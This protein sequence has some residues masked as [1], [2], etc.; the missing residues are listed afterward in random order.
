MT[1]IRPLLVMGTR[2]EAIKMAPVVGACHALSEHLEALICFTGQHDEMLRQVTDYFGIVPDFDLKLMTPGQSLAQLT[3][4]LIVA[5]DE[6]IA[7]AKPDFVVAQG[8]TTSVLA[9]S[10]AAFYRRVP[11]VHV[12]AGLRT[13]D[14]AAPWPEEYNRRVA[15]IGA[16]LHCAPTARS[17]E[18]LRREG[19]PAHQIRV[20][21]NTVIDALLA[22]T[23]RERQRSSHWQEK[24]AW[25][26]SRDLVL[27]TVHRREN[28]GSG[29]DGICTAIAHLADQFTGTAFL[30]PVHLNPQVQD[31]VRRRLAGIDNLRL[32]PPLAY[33]EFV[34]LMERSKL[35]VSDSGGV[36]EEAPSLRRPVVALREA[37]ER[38][39]AVDAG[40]VMCVGSAPDRIVDAAGSLLT[41]H[42][43]YAAM[44]IEK[45]PFGDGHA[46]E[47][48]VE[49]VLETSRTSKTLC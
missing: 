33:P 23:A 14:L 32:T 46:A 30:L 6:T 31:V 7:N 44:Q 13:G 19:V 34:W 26:E 18:N 28:H 21:G 1:R 49:W 47:R 5:L 10:M 36:Q 48:I 40:A 22:T 15:C 27:V 2:P 16:A 37:T 29:L 38:S 43:A 3:S 25:L 45:S 17:A 41:D 8:D 20:T 42:Q 24:H 11:F 35:I 4:K 12:E 39:E 9:A